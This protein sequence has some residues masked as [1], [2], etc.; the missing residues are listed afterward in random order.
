M[1]GE[2]KNLSSSPPT[3]SHLPSEKDIFFGTVSFY[4]KPVIKDEEVPGVLS[5]LRPKK[6]LF[7]PKGSLI[8]LWINKKI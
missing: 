2:K 6:H 3:K 7:K 8:K 1:P 5:E 4:Q